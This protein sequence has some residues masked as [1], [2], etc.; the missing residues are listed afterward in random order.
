MG[1]AASESRVPQAQEIRLEV[2]PRKHIR[3]SIESI[4]IFLYFTLSF[5]QAGP[6]ASPPCRSF[7]MATA[8]FF[9]SALTTGLKQRE[10]SMRYLFAYHPCFG[11]L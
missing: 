8:G 10:K 2:C 4:L 6:S 7:V 3:C 1:G 5:W 9:T 11:R